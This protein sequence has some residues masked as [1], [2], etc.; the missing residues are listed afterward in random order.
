MSLLDVNGQYQLFT[1]IA[2]SM[3]EILNEQRL[4]VNERCKKAIELASG[5]TS[6]YWVNRNEESTLLFL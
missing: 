6:V 3:P 1:P 4:T 5:K 2:K